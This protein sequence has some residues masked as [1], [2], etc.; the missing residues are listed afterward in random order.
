M[1]MEFGKR[2]GEWKR[3]IEIGEREFDRKDGSLKKVI[4]MEC[5]LRMGAN[6]RKG[7]GAT[8]QSL[9]FHCI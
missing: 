9:K 7:G 1:K 3:Q 5:N 8:W 4:Q 2:D 6:F